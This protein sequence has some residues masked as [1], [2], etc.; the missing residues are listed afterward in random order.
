[1]FRAGFEFLEGSV[2]NGNGEIQSPT[3]RVS[4]LSTGV[5]PCPHRLAA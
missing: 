1:M 5:V 2:F 3:A 4:R